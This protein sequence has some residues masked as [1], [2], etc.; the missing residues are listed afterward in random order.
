MFG[1][2]GAHDPLTGDRLVACRRP[3]MELVI[4]PH[5]TIAELGVI[6]RAED[7]HVIADAERDA[8]L[9]YLDRLVCESGGRRGRTAIAGIPREAWEVHATRSAHIDRAVGPEG[10][11]RARAVA[12]RATRDHKTRETVED[13]VGRWRDELIEAGYPPVELDGRV[14]QG[15]LE[16]RPP[17][18]EVLDRLAEDLLGPGGRLAQQKTFNRDDVIIAAA[19][20]LHGLPVSMLDE[21]VERVV[22]HDLAV[23]LPVVGGAVEPVWAPPSV[24][25][26]ERRIADLAEQLITESAPKT[27]W[28]TAAT[29]VSNFET[30]LGLALTDAQRKVAVGLVSSGRQLDVVLGVAGSGKTTTLSAVRAALEEAGYEVIGAATSGQAARTLQAGAGIE[31]RTV[32]SLSWRLDRGQLRLGD[33]HVLILDEAGMTTDTDVGRLLGTVERAGARMIIVGDYRQLDAVGP[34]G[35]LEAIC[36]RH[37]EAVHTLADNLRQVDPAERAALDRLRSGQVEHALAWYASNSG[38]HPAATHNGVVYDMVRAWAA[39]IAAGKD[40]LLLAYRRDNVAALNHAARQAWQALGRLNGPGLHTPDGG[41]FQAGDRIITLT[42]G[43][44]GAWTTSQPATVTAV[45]LDHRALTA[46]TPDGTELHISGEYLGVDRVGY[47]YAITVHRFQGATVDTAHVLADGGGRELAYVAMS[48][49]RGHSHVHLVAV[50]QEHAVE[51]LA[52]DWQVERRQPWTLQPEQPRSALVELYAQRHDL[53][54]A[55]PPNQAHQLHEA[56]AKHDETAQQLDDLY[57]GRGRWAD[58]PAGRAARAY[59]AARRDCDLA[60]AQAES[61]ELGWWARR[62]ANQHLDAMTERHQH[63]L[64]QWTY[65][66]APLAERYQERL[67]H[68]AREVAGVDDGQRARDEYLRQH[69]DVLDRLAEL[70]QAIERAA[71]LERRNRLKRAHGL[72]LHDRQFP[73][74]GHSIPHGPDRGL[75]L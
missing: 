72:S 66:G 51:R 28:E 50:G 60:R 58:H 54:R 16:Y 57:A 35:A 12:A 36:A 32:A 73:S 26:D 53:S 69:P 44:R 31:S 14:R 19:P 74:L 38:V 18:L 2:G 52:W 30:A 59:H 63:A 23:S 13:L 22:G 64:Q 33:R 70:D 41:V 9:D 46:V 3:G 55:I 11:Y 67:D 8:T 7:M 4:S 71:E 25:A 10:S 65:H 40:G 42:P 5:K 68:L 34:G 48:R 37:P 24:V 29:A 39:D 21:V 20:L 56:R 6:G 27:D 43:P 61:P 49:A 17:G 75:S 47:G 15:G 45:D 62:K 1:P